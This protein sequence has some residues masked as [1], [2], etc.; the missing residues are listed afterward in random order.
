MIIQEPTLSEESLSR[1]GALLLHLFTEQSSSFE[2]WQN[3]LANILEAAWAY[4]MAQVQAIQIGY[5]S[6]T[7][8]LVNNCLKATYTLSTQITKQ[9]VLSNPSFGPGRVVGARYS[10]CPAIDN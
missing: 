3:P 8:E 5:L 6:P 1:C 9:Q 10:S 2:F 7:L 4:N